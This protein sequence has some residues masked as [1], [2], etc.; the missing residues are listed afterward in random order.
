[1]DQKLTMTRL[2][3]TII[4]KNFGY[5]ARSLK[6]ATPAEHVIKGQAVLDHDY[7]GDWCPRKHNTPAQQCRTK[8]LQMQDQRRKIVCSITGNLIQHQ[9]PASYV[10]HNLRAIRSS[11]LRNCCSSCVLG[12]D[13]TA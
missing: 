9:T 3:A 12:A 6:C 4:R 8:V 7:C 2:D 1:M 5:M 10:C 11:R 13:L